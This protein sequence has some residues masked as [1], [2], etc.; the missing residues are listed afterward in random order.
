MKITNYISIVLVLFVV[1]LMISLSTAINKVIEQKAEIERLDNNVKVLNDST[2]FYKTRSGEQAAS[3]QQL[4]YTVRDFV[5]FR[6]ADK[7]LIKDLGLKLKQVQSLVK[8]GIITT[9]KDTLLL[10]D[11]II[12]NDN[13]RCFKKFDEYIKLI[14][15]V[16]GDSVEL[17]LAHVDTISNVAHWTYRKWWIFKCKTDVIRLESVSKSPYSRIFFNEYIKIVK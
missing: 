7:I 10:R 4:E 11:T 9:I 2:T 3:V 1:L 6:N 12:I 8:V 5:Q 16:R 13:V 17:D 14:G 15:C